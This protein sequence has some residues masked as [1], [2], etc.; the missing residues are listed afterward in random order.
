MNKN[1]KFPKEQVAQDYFVNQIVFLFGSQSS[2]FLNVILLSS[3]LPVDDLLL[4]LAL[5]FRME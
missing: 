4:N 1:K 3:S 5:R 2:N